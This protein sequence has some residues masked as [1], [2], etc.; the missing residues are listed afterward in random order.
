MLPWRWRIIYWLTFLPLGTVLFSILLVKGV[1]YKILIDPLQWVG[2]KLFFT[3]STEHP[4]RLLCLA[5]M[6]D[7]NASA[8]HR[9]YKYGQFINPAI[10][11]FKIIPPTDMVAFKNLF[12]R[13]KIRRHYLYFIII[14]LRRFAVIWSSPRYDA[15][16]L[17]RDIFSEFFYDHPL[18]IFALRLLNKNIIYDVDDAMWIFPPHS[19][20][21]GSPA[22]NFL[23]RL[24]FYWNVR[25]SRIIIV[26]N[27]YIAEHV[28]KINDAVVV[29]PTLVDT[30]NYPVKQQKYGKTVVIGWTGGPGNLVYLKLLEKTL[31]RLA[32][33]YPIQLRVIS[34]RTIKMKGIEVD[35]VPWD[36][37]TEAENIAAFDIGIMPLHDNFYTQGKGGFKIL[38]YMAAG[39][40]S[41]ASPVGVNA[42]IIQENETGFIAGDDNEWENKLSILIKDASLRNYMGC[43]AREFVCSHYDYEVWSD[44]FIGAVKRGCGY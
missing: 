22:L 34:S 7:E 18:F 13:G 2:R 44:V 8:R 41:V 43:K 25:L 20:R 10:I 35:F 11:V 31:A 9:L 1:V 27:Q 23:T 4:I 42:Q 29:I 14:F 39:L 21:G 30:G 17:Q 32:L 5:Y 33:K 16:F 37:I 6:N 28:E 40:P 36:K 19:I 38:E 3:K 26:S 12:L 15:V 24:R